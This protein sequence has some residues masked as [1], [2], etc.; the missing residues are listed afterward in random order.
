MRIRMKTSTPWAL[1][2]QSLTP[3]VVNLLRAQALKTVNPSRHTAHAFARRM[4]HAV[5]DPSVSTVKKW[6]YGLQVSVSS[7]IQLR[8]RALSAVV[9][10]QRS[11]WL[12]KLWYSFWVLI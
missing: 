12:S 6:V 10:L 2:P 1:K 9:N 4:P 5:S 7:S 3:K 8:Y 11:G